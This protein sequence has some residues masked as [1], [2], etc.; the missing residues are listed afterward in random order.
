[1]NGFKIIYAFVL[2]GLVQS[3][4]ATYSQDISSSFKVYRNLD[5]AVKHAEAVKFLD[6]S[7]KQLKEFPMEILMLTEL[8]VL[9]LADN[10]L[11]LLPKEI[12]TLSQLER[13]E[14]QRN[15]IDVLPDEMITMHN[16]KRINL[17][18][19]SINNEDIQYLKEALAKCKIIFEV[20]L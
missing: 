6:L 17:Q 11:I 18:Y 15:N 8:R 9:I 20:V 3:C 10:D 4:G 19:N 5:K 7:G 16:L 13:L 2:A 12:S 14:L 1:M